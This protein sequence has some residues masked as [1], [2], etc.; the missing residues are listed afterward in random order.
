MRDKVR[1]ESILC[2]SGTSPCIVQQAL[3]CAAVMA[4]KSSACAL[5]FRFYPFLHLNLESLL[6]VAQVQLQ[7]MEVWPQ[8]PYFPVSCF[9]KGQ[10]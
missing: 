8:L 9:P 2:G 1:V 4:P 7:Q 10:Q 3:R 6:R 5:N